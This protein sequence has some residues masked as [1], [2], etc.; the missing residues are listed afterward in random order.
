[1]IIYTPRSR[2]GYLF[3]V[4]LT[5]I[6]WAAFFYLLAG[7][8][9]AILEGRLQGPDMPLWGAFLPTIGT[10]SSY[11]LV[12]TINAAI[13]VGWAVYNHW[14]FGGVDRRK[15]PPPVRIAQL[16]H[17]FMLVPNTIREACAAKIMVIYH[18]EAG[19]ITSISKKEGEVKK[20]AAAMNHV[21]SGSTRFNNVDESLYAA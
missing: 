19:R 4:V 18:D 5:L 21:M 2:V 13:L 8:I 6:A 14:R 1:M 11:L 12:A 20:S 7:G 15:S 17:S 3:D 10:L 16:A 9:L